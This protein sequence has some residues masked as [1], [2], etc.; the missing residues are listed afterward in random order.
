MS[1]SRADVY[2]MK[3]LELAFER[4]IK[5]S[6]SVYKNYFRDEYN[7]YALSLKD[8]LY[9]LRRRMKV[10]FLPGTTSLKVYMPKSTG[11]NRM[12]TLLP[13]EDQIVYQAYANIIAEAIVNKKVRGRYGK[14]VFGNQYTDNSDGF[15]SRIGKLH[16]MSIVMQ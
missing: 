10:G 9:D 5:N 14:T 16:T 15:F 6:E 8:N 3:N 11:L 13:I 1:F 12:Y 2:K 4:L 7:A